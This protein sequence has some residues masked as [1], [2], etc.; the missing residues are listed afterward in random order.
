MIKEI[1]IQQINMLN[2]VNKL[3]DIEIDV[4][5]KDEA[6][7]LVNIVEEKKEIDV[8]TLKT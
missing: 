3:L 6:S 2:E 5:K 7:K 1:I 4:L 8:R